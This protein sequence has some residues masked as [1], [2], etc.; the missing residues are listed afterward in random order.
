ME[1]PWHWH[2]MRTLMARCPEA[3]NYGTRLMCWSS[4]TLVAFLVVYLLIAPRTCASVQDCVEL[5]PSTRLNSYAI[6]GLSTALLLEVLSLHLSYQSAKP[7]LG[8]I[9]GIESTFLPPALLCVS[10]SVLML[11]NYVLLYRPGLIHAGSPEVWPKGDTMQVL[12]P[13]YVEWLL[14]MPILLVLAGTC[15]LRRPLHEITRPLV[16]TN[17]YITIAWGAHFVSCTWMRWSMIALA[18]GMYGAASW[19]M[20]Q[21]INSFR[22]RLRDQAML[23]QRARLTYALIVIFGL[24][25]IVYLA[26]FMG[27]L[28][29]EQER[30]IY[31]C[32]NI[33]SKLL[34]LVAFAG[35]RSSQYHELLINMLVNTHLPFQRQIAV[36]E[37]DPG[38]SNG[39]G[40]FHQQLLDP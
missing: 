1:R 40:D 39:Q 36:I 5:Q 29:G 24:Y 21:W 37:S 28:G 38:T 9:E 16:V 23:W 34:L 10:L 25:G 17:V 30:S 8:L 18:F 32:M 7:A 4:T 31:T 2:D 11:E 14:N 20:L 15:A 13:I 33:G 3:W 6:I 27:A 35:I 22:S 12:T 26:R 19:D